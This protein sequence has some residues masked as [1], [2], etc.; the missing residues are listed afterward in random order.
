MPLVRIS[1]LRGKSAEY[2]RKVGDAAHEALVEAIGVPAK[3]RFQIITRHDP[4]DFIAS[5]APEPSS[6]QRADEQVAA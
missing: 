6:E 1:L 3:D 4:E 2:R 5:Y